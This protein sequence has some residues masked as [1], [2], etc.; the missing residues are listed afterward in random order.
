MPLHLLTTSHRY[1]P[2][3]QHTNKP[4]DYQTPIQQATST[5]STLM[6]YP[7]WLPNWVSDLFRLLCCSRE[8]RRFRGSSVRM[9]RRWR[10]LSRRVWSQ[11]GRDLSVAGLDVG[12]FWYISSAM[13][14]MMGTGTEL[15]QEWM[16]RQPQ[17]SAICHFSEEQTFDCHN[18]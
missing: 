2:E 10:W 5:S 13:R 18:P 16:T 11:G 6:T 7:K 3:A 1:I 17:Y 4:T 9:R 12:S 8:G 15:G 14:T